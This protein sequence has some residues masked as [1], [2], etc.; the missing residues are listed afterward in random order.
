M[1]VCV[2]TCAIV[3]WMHMYVCVC[4]CILVFMFFAYV[5]IVGM[6]CV[7]KGRDFS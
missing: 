1:C 3:G 4:V 6:W 5:L 2:D 7:L